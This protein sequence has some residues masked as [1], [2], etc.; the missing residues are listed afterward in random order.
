VDYATR[1]YRSRK[2]YVPHELLSF[3]TAARP[4]TA[5]R[6]ARRLG[7]SDSAEG[8]ES[9]RGVPKGSKVWTRERRAREDRWR[10]RILQVQGT[11]GPS[12]DLRSLED[13]TEN[14][15]HRLRLSLPEL[16]RMLKK[17]LQMQALNI[18]P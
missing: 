4:E 16:K 17:K 12:P 10:R 6:E 5:E 2:W 14:E 11:Q 18:G 7:E 8:Q 15:W 1:I 13:G 3:E 9:T